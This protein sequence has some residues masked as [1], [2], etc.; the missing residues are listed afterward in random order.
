MVRR[1]MREEMGSVLFRAEERVVAISVRLRGGG[2][3]S[4][5]ERGA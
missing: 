3:G 5:E 1:R 2:L 4:T